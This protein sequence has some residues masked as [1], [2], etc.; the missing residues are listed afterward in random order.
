MPANP[1]SN[2]VGTPEDRVVV[3]SRPPGVAVVT[4]DRFLCDQLSRV[5]D[6]VLEAVEGMCRR[7]KSPPR[8]PVEIA[9]LFA[10]GKNAPKFGTELRAFLHD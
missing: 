4:P 7:L 8:S 5:P 6:L 1:S 9:Q 2:L 10:S 3:R